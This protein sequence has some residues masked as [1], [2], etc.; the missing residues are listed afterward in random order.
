MVNYRLEIIA[1]KWGYAEH[2]NFMEKLLKEPKF[3]GVDITG[4]NNCINKYLE[5]DSNYYILDF[6]SGKLKCVKVNKFWNKPGEYIEGKLVFPE[7]RE[8]LR[9]LLG[10]NPRQKTKRKIQ[11]IEPLNEGLIKGNLVREKGT[12]NLNY[13][14]ERDI[15]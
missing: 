8:E 15:K 2:L 13:Y 5:L 14:F 9:E 11:I 12:L 4:I 10:E 3:L 1:P 6:E 7:N